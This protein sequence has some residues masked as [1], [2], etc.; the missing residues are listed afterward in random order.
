MPRIPYDIDGEQVTKLASYGCT[1]EEIADFFGCD[2]TVIGRRYA[3]EY[4]L[5]KAKVRINVRMWQVRRARKGSDTMLVHLG[6][7]YCGQS[8]K[9]EN[10]TTHDL[11]EGLTDRLHQAIQAYGYRTPP[12]E[13]MG[14]ADAGPFRDPGEFG[15]VEDSS[16]SGL[17]ES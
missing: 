4:E 12:G 14:G 3:R 11:P 16:S 15:E 9:T 5:G 7:Q 10:K 8:D 13:D 2:R 17:S 1:Q 6:K